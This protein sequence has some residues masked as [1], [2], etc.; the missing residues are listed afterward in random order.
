MGN[1]WNPET[2]EPK[3]MGGRK[4]RYKEE[5][6]RPGKQ[7]GA[8]WSLKSKDKEAWLQGMEVGEE[9]LLEQ[10]Q[11]AILHQILTLLWALRCFGM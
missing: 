6:G 8:Q 5:E 3:G 11:G 4:R 9:S 7:G 2:K 10:G 1:K